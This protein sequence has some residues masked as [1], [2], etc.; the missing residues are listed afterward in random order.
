M[1]ER[2]G[3]Y[4]SQL[5]E[6][7]SLTD[8]MLFATDNGADNNSVSAAKLAEYVNKKI[9]VAGQVNNGVSEANSYADTKKT[10]AVTEAKSYADTKKTEAV[11]ETKAWAQ[12]AFGNPNLL[13][14]SNFKN[15]VNQRGITSG[16]TN[17]ISVYTI[18]RWQVY[19]NTSSNSFIIDEN[20][21]TL[22]N[23]ANTGTRLM[24]RI[25]YEE[26]KNL[27]GKTVTIS[28]YCS[29]MNVD[30]GYFTLYVSYDN[31]S[32][33]L[34]VGSYKTGKFIKTF[35]IPELSEDSVF[36]V[37]V[38]SSGTSGLS[39]TFEWLKLELG[40]IATPFVPRPYGEELAL[41]QRYYYEYDNDCA[42][43][44]ATNATT[45]I[46]FKLSLPTAMRTKPT[47]TFPT[48]LMRGAGKA[49]NA[50]YALTNPAI[51]KVSNNTII[52][53][54]AYDNTYY[55]PLNVFWVYNSGGKLILD[56]EIY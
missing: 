37:M 17:G 46:Y 4:I 36:V 11:S 50:S 25:P 16:T 15:P 45:T 22:T 33:W 19:A 41:C 1:A 5:P 3:I 52:F 55:P 8:N 14:N 40:E 24:Q 51:Y 54:A 23:G 13:L 21:I 56:A 39:V 35:T 28:G 44:G 7:T 38:Q 30:S 48:L 9:D 26:C 12:G 18:D 43:D 47:A 53:Y 20:G 31:S 27:S 42:Y 10:E 2:E 29:N 49:A 34:N 32:Q 6:S